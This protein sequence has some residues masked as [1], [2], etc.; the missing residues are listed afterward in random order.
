MLLESYRIIARAIQQERTI[1]CLLASDN[2]AV[3]R[4]F[5]MSKF[6]NL[7]FIHT[8]TVGCT[9]CTFPLHRRAARG[10]YIY[11][12]GSWR[13]VSANCRQ[14]N[15]CHLSY[16]DQTI[17]GLLVIIVSNGEVGECRT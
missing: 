15:V 4:S 3:A 11:Y 17:A 10:S 5:F 6:R 12:W 1:S 8:T 14:L 7:S 16:F 13:E 9:T 2:H